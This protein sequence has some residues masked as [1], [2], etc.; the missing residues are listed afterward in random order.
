VLA[1]CA[2]LF[3]VA[4]ASLTFAQT[5]DLTVNTFDDASSINACDVE[6][7]TGEAT[8]DGTQGNPAGACLVTV[9]FSSSSD[10]PVADYFCLPGD[11]PWWFQ[12][13]SIDLSLYA[14][15]DFDIMY[16][17]TSDIDIPHFNDLST[18]DTTMT[19]KNG[20]KVMQSWA[21]SGYLSGSLPGLDICVCGSYN[22][23]APSIASTNI[24]AAAASGW[25][26]VSIPINP[27]EANIG[28]V[29]GIVI[30]KWIN[31]QWGIANDAQARFWIDN[32]VFKGNQLPP[33]LPAVSVPTNKATP[34]LN[35]FASTDNQ[36]YDRQSAVLRQTNGLSWVGHATPS[37]P[38]SYSF[39]IVGYP[40]STNCEAWMFLC[41][42]PVA[43][44]NA[45]DWNETNCAIVF[46]QK[47]AAGAT[48]HFQYKVGESMGQNMYSGAGNYTAAPGTGGGTLPESGNLAAVNATTGVYG[49]WTL[50][51]TSDTAGQLIAPDG[52]SASFTFPSYNAPQFAES[53][54]GGFYIYLGM[55]ANNADAYNHAVVYSNFAVS[56]TAAPYSE[57]FLAD[58]VL[59]TTNVWNTSA[60]SGPAG[61][62]IVPA[63][64]STA[65]WLEWTLPASGF[66]LQTSPT[67]S[68]GSFAWTSPTIGPVI[69][70]VG[71][72]QQL[73]STSELPIGNAAFFRLIKRNFTQLQILL[74]GE[75]AAPNT[76]TGKTGTPTPVS[77]GDPDYGSE[78]VTVNA[79]D[80]NWNI[81][82]NVSDT[83]SLTCSD[84]YAFL[85]LDAAMVNGTVTF[86]GNNA[87]W[88]STEGSQTITATDMTSGSIPAATSSPVMV[89]P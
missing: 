2:A 28:S 18:W 57:N 85:P 5:T 38:V 81:V 69:G 15:V 25:T 73:V 52:H 49:T 58:T 84:D 45:P 17:N 23:M 79:V 48:G 35:V 3:L 53:N 22:Q 31:Q 40:N 41:P 13:P 68:G 64:D 67:L 71:V 72:G 26:H 82:N 39:T 51:F 14:S 20:S 6:W 78:N 54:P 1:T 10:T 46:L 12:T 47:N 62:L 44:D 34:G 16:D 89:D 30:H 27:A 70:M 88:F 55:Q 63:A 11:N 65:L 33:H 7:G 50:K 43:M 75:T 37:H 36:I 66:S 61:M 59:D 74:P 29:N 60:A 83:I 77:W 80:S 76:P 21:G 4:P 32:I 8:W 42:N 86:S 24:P 87:V 56:N 9:V 19:N